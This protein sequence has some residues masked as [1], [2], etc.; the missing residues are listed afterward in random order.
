MKIRKFYTVVLS[1]LMIISSL[2]ACEETSGI[3]VQPTETQTTLTTIST[4]DTT[5]TTTTISETT[6]EATTAAPPPFRSAKE[7]VDDMDVGI[8][9]SNTFESTGYESW[10]N[11]STISEMET[12][13]IRNGD[14]RIK[15]KYVTTEELINTIADA[16]FDSIRIP[17][18]WSKALE[19]D[20]LTIRADFM[21]R[22][23]EVVDWSLNAGMYVIINV[24]HDN[25][26]FA[27]WET[28]SNYISLEDSQMELSK[29]R[30]KSLWTQISDE[31]K[32]YDD[33]LI[34][35]GINEPREVGFPEEWTTGTDAGV[36]NLNTLLELF[37]KTVRESGGYNADRALM[38]TE[39]VGN[40]ANFSS[41]VLP[42]DD[43]LI[44]SF[45]CYEPYLFTLDGVDKDW[46]SSNPEDTDLMNENF[47][48]AYEKY[49]SKSI[50]A[51]CGEF[52][53]LQLDAT[54]QEDRLAYTDY[55]LKTAEDSNIPGF[56][57]INGQGV[58]DR[59][60]CEWEQPDLLEVIQKY[61]D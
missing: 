14:A 18:T 7:I 58:I 9:L 54:P 34:F 36:K 37:V 44:I 1:L 55:F 47:S 24:H 32:Y 45:H 26:D 6:T 8:N 3:T 60:T 28:R 33:R 42:E 56:L 35:E 51:I 15:A 50:P 23:K 4:T 29:K 46:S 39:Y 43:N 12:A 27:G 59:S 5:P 13:W 25:G 20:D 30:F 22:I 10:H 53:A 21:A 2:T 48:D 40:P 17:V 19:E 11:I 57:W 52:G 49:V 38:V 16:G 61:M 31:F 41:L